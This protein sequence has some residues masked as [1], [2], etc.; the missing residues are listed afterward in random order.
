MRASFL[1]VSCTL[2]TLI[3]A[4]GTAMGADAVQQQDWRAGW[5]EARNA[6]IDA[7]PR[8]A[9][10][11]TSLLV[12]FRDGADPA[13]IAAAKSAAGVLVEPIETWK[14]VPGVEHLAVD[15]GVRVE[16]AIKVL[17]ASA[18][19]EYAE[20]DQVA[21]LAVNPNDTHFP[22]LWGMSNTGQTV[23]GD[24]GVANADID[25]DLAWGVTTGSNLVVAVCDSGIRRSHADLTSNIWSNPGEVAGNGIDDDGNGRVDDT[26]GWNFWSNNNNPVDDNGHGTHVAGT[27][28]ARGN[29]GAGVAG[30]CWNVKLA[31]LRIA[32]ANGSILMT[33]AISAVDYCRTKN[34]RLANHSWGGTQANATLQTAISNARGAGHILCVAAGNDNR[35]NDSTPYYPASYNFDNIIAVG[36][37]TND[38]L[39]ASYSN[40]GAASVDVFA[41]GTTIASC[42]RTN[43]TSYVYMSGTSMATPH[44]TGVCALVMSRYPAWTS[45]QVRARVISSCKAVPNLAGKCVSG[46]CVNAWNAVQ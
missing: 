11:P 23:N 7:N 32:N 6:L 30:V 2:L 16:F 21:Q 46:G 28:G 27:I 18:C 38:N 26:W 43:D 41:P 22:L 29:N 20:P 35:N 39:R 44:V 37:I 40:F 31:S 34:I 12:K 3:A 1:A 24:P 33:A 25:A 17:G 13:C 5:L 10:D 8:L 19:V 9:Y 42:Y 36:A 15:K 4:S 45:T 14:S